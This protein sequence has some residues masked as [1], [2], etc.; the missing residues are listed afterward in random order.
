MC[1]TRL[2]P[3]SLALFSCLS[4]ATAVQADDEQNKDS[5]LFIGE[6]IEVVHQN[7]AAKEAQL[8]G[9]IDII[10]RDQLQNEHVNVTVDLLKK[11]PGVYFSR[12]NQGII[13]T[14]NH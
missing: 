5:T 2:S 7:S 8:V 9:S 4:L 3:I 11:V 6:V 10:N 14:D 13:S 1:S 12:F